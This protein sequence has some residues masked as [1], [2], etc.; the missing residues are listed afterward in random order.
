MSLLSFQGESPAKSKVHIFNDAD[1]RSLST[2]RDGKAE[3]IV[4][5]D[6][7]MLR[8]K[9]FRHIRIITVDQALRILK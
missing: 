9:T 1:D 5:G 3:I 7:H 4:T 8:L 2:A 6:K